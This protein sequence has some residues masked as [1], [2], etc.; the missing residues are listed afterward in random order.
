[1]KAGGLELVSVLDHTGDLMCWG[2]GRRGIPCC[3]WMA[4]AEKLHVWRLAGC[5]EGGDGYHSKSGVT[6]YVAVRG[7]MLLD[8]AARH[9]A[10]MGIG[11]SGR[12]WMRDQELRGDGMVAAGP[13]RYMRNPLYVGSWLG[14]SRWRC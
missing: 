14:R 11:V 8:I 10:D 3:T 9:A 13:Y 2:S 4:R 1:M 6:E 12:R 7:I 5:G